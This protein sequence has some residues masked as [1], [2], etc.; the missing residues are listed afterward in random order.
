M[1]ATRAR[2][3]PRSIAGECSVCSTSHSGLL[4]ADL[5]YCLLD[6]RHKWWCH[7][8]GADTRRKQERKHVHTSG[9]F[10]AQGQ[11][12]VSS[13][14]GDLTEQSLHRGMVVSEVVAHERVLTTCRH[15]VLRQI[16]RSDAEKICMLLDLVHA[17]RGGRRL[18]H[19]AQ[20]WQVLR[21]DVGRGGHQQFPQALHFLRQLYHPVQV[22]EIS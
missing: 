14:F 18:D 16:V 19:G 8:E 15:R 17:E 1:S 12:C 7:A 3:P 20:G 9:E 6:R 5:S 21:P 22:V 4:D 2:V 10:T 11:R 13:S